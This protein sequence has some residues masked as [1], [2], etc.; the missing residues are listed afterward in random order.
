MR[1]LQ[2]ILMTVTVGLVAGCA[3][4]QLAALDRELAAIR[5][6]PGPTPAFEMPEVPTYQATPY[7]EAD[8]RSPFRP[9]RPE[10]D[11]E[12]SGEGLLAPDPERRKEPLE[13]FALEELALVGVLTVGGER[14]ALVRTPDGQVHRLREGNY[15]GSNHG[16]IVAITHSSVQLVELVPTGGGGWVE[17][18]TR[19][20]LDDDT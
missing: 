2:G 16:R 11:P 17:R 6:D 12:A 18:T 9:H 8:S 15:L 13:G 1:W 3:D 10:T 4:P 20:T 7:R 5:D 14:S 19:L